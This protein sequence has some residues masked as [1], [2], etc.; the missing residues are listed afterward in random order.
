MNPKVI[1]VIILLTVRVYL[2]RTTAQG[3]AHTDTGISEATTSSHAD[4]LTV[5]P[6]HLSTAALQQYPTHSQLLQTVAEAEKATIPKY[7]ESGNILSSFSELASQVS[8]SVF[9]RRVSE[10]GRLL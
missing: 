2:N 4:T 1:R 3:E 10:L 6:L 5:H 9:I 7:M 8:Y